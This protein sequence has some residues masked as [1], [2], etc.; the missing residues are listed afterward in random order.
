MSAAKHGFRDIAKLK[1]IHR[2][3]DIWIVGSG[4]TLNYVD[5]KFFDNKITLGINHIYKWFS[6]DYVV[7]KDFAE[8]DRYTEVWKDLIPGTDY[9]PDG[10]IKLLLSEYCAGQY[11]APH[12]SEYVEPRSN[13]HMFTHNDNSAAGTR[14]PDY[15]LKLDFIDKKSQTI[16]CLK[17]TLTTAMHLAAYM[18]AE[19]IIISGCDNG[20]I[21][22]N[23]Y[24]KGYVQSHWKT[25][26]NWPRSKINGWLAG[27]VE[28]NVTVRDKIIKEYGCNIYSLN[29]FINLDLENHEYIPM[30]LK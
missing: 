27:I 11:A 24:V 28:I 20:E 25:G 14:N 7:C 1:N 17:S 6:C 15:S 9:N 4:P 22:G 19:N 30:R 2:G 3:K 21:D 13:F 12:N 10:K 23:L 29:P 5:K 8:T 26:G 16:I 18:G